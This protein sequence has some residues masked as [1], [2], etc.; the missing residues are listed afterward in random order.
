MANFLNELGLAGLIDD[1]ET[2]RGFL[3]DV[4]S[5]GKVIP[6]YYGYPYVNKHY[7]ST[8]IIARTAPNE[9]ADGLKLAGFDTHADSMCVWEFRIEKKMTNPDEDD[10]TRVRLFTKALD[11]SCPLI[12]DV[13][14]GDILPSFKTDEII[15]LQMIAFSDH[16]EFYA[17]EDEYAESVKPGHNGRKIMIGEN[18]IFPSGLFIDNEEI[19]DVVQIH[20]TGT[21]FSSIYLIRNMQ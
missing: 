17:D 3:G 21:P 20:G 4:F 18:T 1:E 8:Q 10:P 7:G 19:K 15:K 12:I 14:N 16:A 9:D 13:V 2:A 11:G 5:S 6:N